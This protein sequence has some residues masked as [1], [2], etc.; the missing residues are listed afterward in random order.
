MHTQPA[1][2]ILHE[3]ATDVQALQ[4]ETLEQRELPAG[5]QAYVAMGNLYV[6]G[7][8]S[9][10]FIQVAQSG[11]QVSV[12]GVQINLNGKNVASVNASSI[13]QAIVYG[14]DGND[15][16]DLTTLK[17]NATIYEVAPGNDIV[18]CGSGND[19][20]SGGT[21]FDQVFRSYNPLTPVINGA[22]EADIRQGPNPLC[23]TD[24]A[25]GELAQQGHNFNSDI[26]YLGNNWYLV[27]LRRLPP[28]KKVYFD[29]WT[30]NNDPVT[31]SNGEFLD[32]PHASALSPGIPRHRPDQVVHPVP[33]GRDE[34]GDQ[35]SPLLRLRCPL[36][37]H[38]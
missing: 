38:R 20:I 29:G 31:S 14:Y 15:V 13:S 7:T 5:L 19:V 37:L 34:Q 21:G 4:A 1:A 11:S 9:N 32:G 12:T 18:R 28:P 25:L 23:Q 30:N 26:Q 35:L 24:A 16:I 22:T 27:K 17:N 10:D 8:N 36:H 33:V 2:E 3:N 6:L